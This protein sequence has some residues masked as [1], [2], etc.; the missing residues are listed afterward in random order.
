MTI[1]PD[2]LINSILNSISRIDYIR[3]DSLPD[4][5]LYMDQ[6]TTFGQPHGFY[7]TPSRGQNPYQNHDQQLC[8][9]QPASSSCKEEVFQRAYADPDFYLL[10]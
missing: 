9:K 3:P 8:Q 2:D 10:F 4:I 1:N 6:V 7:Q 5:D